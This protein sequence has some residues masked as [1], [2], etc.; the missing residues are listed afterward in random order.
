MTVH[1]MENGKKS[2]AFNL[3]T[4][5]LTSNLHLVNLHQAHMSVL[6]MGRAKQSSIIL[7]VHQSIR[8]ES[9]LRIL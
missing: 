6:K 8:E 7:S 4:V 3:V 9:H 2:P 5:S 1:A